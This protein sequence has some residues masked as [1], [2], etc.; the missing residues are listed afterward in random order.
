MGYSLSDFAKV[1]ETITES[2]IIDFKN[3]GKKN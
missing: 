1:Y 2:E 3:K